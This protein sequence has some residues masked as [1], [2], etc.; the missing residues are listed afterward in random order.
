MLDAV[1]ARVRA[2]AAKA[3]RT[4]SRANKVPGESDIVYEVRQ[5]FAKRAFPEFLAACVKF[6]RFNTAEF[7]DLENDI[8]EFASKWRELP[9]AGQ[10]KRVGQHAGLEDEIAAIEAKA[11]NL[12]AEAGVMMKKNTIASVPARTVEVE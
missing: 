5:S 9:T 6:G 2:D 12:Q 3:R 7:L 11:A 8:D 4:D 10:N 1:M